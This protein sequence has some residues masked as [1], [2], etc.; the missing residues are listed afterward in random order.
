MREK[1]VKK[2]R[3]FTL[4]E[5][6]IVLVI[7]GIL[8]AAV[9]KGQE[10]IK[11]AKIKRIYNDYMGY[12]A[13]INTYQD[14]YSALPGDDPNAVNRFKTGSSYCTYHNGDNDGRMDDEDGTT[15]GYYWEHLRCAGI[16][17]G[18]GSSHPKHALGGR[19]YVNYNDYNISGHTL[20]FTNIPGDIAEIIDT[21]HDDGK[22]NSGSI[23]GSGSTDSYNSATSYTLCFAM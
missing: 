22:A 20:C 7:I 11:N 16:I 19:V 3:G 14:R 12:V 6:S 21:K 10:I 8:L 18:S 23:Q 4:V 5:L 1:G 15:Y 17:T 2:Q 9:L 13:A